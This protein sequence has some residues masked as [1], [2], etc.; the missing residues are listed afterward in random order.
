[1]AVR[2]TT[3]SR[4][5]P[6]GPGIAASAAFGADHAR[7][8]AAFLRGDGWEAWR[9]LGAHGDQEGTRFAV[10]APGAEAVEVFGRFD[11]GE[12][13]RAEPMRRVEADNGG[14]T[15][16]WWTRVSGCG[17][18][19]PYK[20]K[21]RC[22]GR[23]LERADPFAFASEHTGGIASLTVGPSSRTWRDG[24]WLRRRSNRQHRTQPLS[25]YEVH[26]G[27]WRHRVRELGG[28][29]ESLSY[30]ELAPAL[31]AH[32]HQLGFTHVEFLPLAEH[33]YYPSWG[34]QTTG[35]FAPTSRFVHQPPGA[36]RGPECAADDF[37]WLVNELHAAGIGVLIDWSPA[38]FP[39]DEGALREFDGTPLFEDKNPLRRAHPEWGTLVFDYGHPA[40][41]SFLLSAAH[42]WLEAFH[43]DG[44][45]VDAVA[46]MLY[47]DYGRGPG[48][49]QPNRFGGRENLEAVAF[50]QDFTDMVRNAGQGALTVA[51]ES[52]DFPGVTRL[53][54]PRAERSHE[55]PYQPGLGFDFKWNMGWMHDTLAYL[56]EDPLFRRHHHDRITFATLYRGHE[57]WMLPLSHDEVVHRKGALAEKVLRWVH[58]DD[59]HPE[60]VARRL[61]R[62]SDEG[63]PQL[64][65]LFGYQWTFPGKKL[66]FMGQEFGQPTEWA[67]DLGLPWHLAEEPLRR[68]LMAWLGALNALYR[69]HPSLHQLDCEVDGYAWVEGNDRDN[70]ILVWQ[71]LA[72]DGRSLVVVAHLTGTWLEGHWLPMPAVG[73][74]RVLLSSGDP[75]FGGSVAPPATVHVEEA[76]GR[77]MARLDLPGYALVVLE[78]LSE[79]PIET[80]A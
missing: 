1:M 7:L 31:I 33:P 47:L 26:L 75:Q 35:Y 48:Q 28:A 38:H 79:A 43:V 77:P 6:A 61:A 25:V 11:A 73:E 29:P 55:Q 30:R 34:Y 32:V 44:F 22:G 17:A 62:W 57:A 9:V 54:P 64:R 74:Y 21:L 76:W 39:A 5:P 71:R 10:W 14:A 37:A 56:S 40:V 72:R 52:T 80:D 4:R 45:R 60:V 36:F 15:G 19:V 46:S 59:S 12:T 67:Y 50:L 42:Y 70:S 27:S 63:A 3:R 20:F 16:V 65:L 78:P 58:R 13:W 51:E 2:S 23:W 53:P 8:L 49:W 18:G 41:K 24:D 69:Q 66:L 68:Q